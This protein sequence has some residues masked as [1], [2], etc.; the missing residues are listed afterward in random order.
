MMIDRGT[1]TRDEKLVRERH[2]GE[3]E[4]KLVT[5]RRGGKKRGGRVKERWRNRRG[6]DR[7]AIEGNSSIFRDFIGLRNN[8]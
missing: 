7:R 6:R 2:R 5:L 8:S 1:I 4:K 3:A